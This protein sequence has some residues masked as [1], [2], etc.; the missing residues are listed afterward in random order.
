M[1]EEL[2]LVHS[3]RCEK[4]ADIAKARSLIPQLCPVF[5]EPLIYLFYGRPA[6]RSKNG[7]TPST[8]IAY[9]PVCFVFKPYTISAQLIRLFPFD[10]GASKGGLFE[11]HIS[12]TDTDNFQL[13]LTLES[14]RRTINF[15]FETNAKFFVGEPKRGLFIPDAELEALNYYQLV[16]HEGDEAYD[17]R[18]SAIEVQA[19][20]AIELRDTLL[21]VILPFSFL[22]ESDIRKVIV[23]DW[24]TYPITY[25]TVRGTIPSE[26]VRVIAEKLRSYLEDGGYL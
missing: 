13:S 17:D 9:C 8:D 2:P 22:Q 25:S 7:S 26:Y 18:R 10:S 5:G 15:F 1:N 14:A 20:I 24:R 6:Y 4:F 19:N 21:A 12:R 23:K 11:P 3:T 16:S